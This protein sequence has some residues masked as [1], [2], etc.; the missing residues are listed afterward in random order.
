M[1]TAPPK[2]RL[3]LSLPASLAIVAVV[4]TLITF[5]MFIL[6]P[7]S[8]GGIW[9]CLRESGGAVF[10]LNW[11]PVFL[12]TLFL[13]FASNNVTISCGLPAAIVVLL[14]VINRNMIYMR[15]EPFKPYDILLEAE[16]FGIAKSIDTKIF[17]QAI[18]GLAAFAVLFVLCLWFVKSK[19]MRLSLR[20]TGS[21]A[22]L[23][24]FCCINA[25]LIG[26]VDLY[27]S[28]SVTGNEF[29]QLDNYQSK[30]FLYSFL[31]TF[32]T[33][34][35]AKPDTYEQDRA[36]IL[37]RLRTFTPASFDHAVKPNIVLILSEAYSDI[38]LSPH[39]NFDGY[40][41]PMAHFQTIQEES[42]VGHLVVPNVGG[43][44]SN[45]EFDIFT[46]ISTRHFRGSAYAYA[47]ITK[48]IQALPSLLADIGYDNL[49]LHP[50]YKWFYNR[51]VVYPYL[52]FS[53]FLDIEDFDE[54][55][56]KGMYVTEAQTIQRVIA[57]YENQTRARPGVPFFEACV[58]IQNHGP[59]KNKYGEADEVPRNFSS[60]IAFSADAENALTNYIEGM[61]DCDREL[62]VL[63]DYLRGRPEPAVLVYYGDHLPS[64][65]HDV[66]DALIPGQ[67]DNS[68]WGVT[69]LYQTPFIIWQNDAA[70]SQTPIETVYRELG[71]D[72]SWTISSNYLGVCLLTL[73]G[74][75]GLDPFVDY[76]GE[77]AQHY[78]VM[79][80]RQ[81]FNSVH[82][83]EVT[84]E[85]E[86]NSVN[87][88]RSW[89]Y[90]KIFNH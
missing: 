54:E 13:Y 35:I 16:F 20:L 59:Y 12:P 29:N 56:I 10:W 48:P 46:G 23:S 18:A 66:Y 87:F 5:V 36:E 55:D 24:L 88:Y 70:R 30:G 8:G 47:L 68:L 26:N 85:Q 51:H 71:L 61:L 4:S 49:A 25:A 22:A 84:R 73:L 82:Q 15:Q 31:Y 80:E 34:R 28:F 75:S 89:A 38:L 42:I 11:T 77:L 83:W 3:W 69:R 19:R 1:Q 53:R 43:A 58:T 57:E 37:E 63:A 7:A 21:L 27:Q 44:T 64:F 90:Y 78:P 2:F 50:G 32:G 65:T 41:D 40:P 52:G 81:S 60:D 6:Q 67:R 74:F 86:R 62:A 39:L 9:D 45:T 33:N 14:S 72:A 79:L 76:V 17:Q